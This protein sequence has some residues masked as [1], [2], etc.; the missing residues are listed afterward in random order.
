[1]KKIFS[2]WER[3]SI[4][5]IK[6]TIPFGNFG[7]PITNSKPEFFY[8]QECYEQ[9]KST[10]AKFGGF[11][12]YISPIF[13]PIDP[14]YVK[15]ILVKDFQTFQARG[16]NP[17][18][19][20]PISMNLF[21]TDGE[22][23]SNLRSKFTPTFTA[24]KLKGMF[25]IIVAATEE[26]NKHIEDHA[27]KR[28]PLNVKDCASRLTATM[29]TSCAFGI[30]HNNFQDDTMVSLL[31]EIVLKGSN[32]VRISIRM[33]L[34]KLANLLRIPLIMT[35][36]SS[37]ICNSLEEIV[38]YRTEKG[39]SREDFLQLLIEMKNEGVINLN[40]LKA[41]SMIFLLAGFETSSV[42][43]SFL[44]Y[45]L[46][47]NQDLQEKLRN[48]INQTLSKYNE[49]IITYEAI[50]EMNYLEMVLCGKDCFFLLSF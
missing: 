27:I 24:A 22:R 6:P 48:E 20:Q 30:E 31:E 11:Y 16:F 7:N 38:K 17:S 42:T 29:I 8:L 34:P 3:M 35:K 18:A 41:Q 19:N 25:N 33:A 12:A 46:A 49:K 44:L 13:L 37:V 47:K 39:V 9:L 5:F 28:S 23:W 50:M 36:Q 45:E 15:Y 1:M 14:E 2:Y 21:T 43:I 32:L 10:G 26:M 4:P 40:E